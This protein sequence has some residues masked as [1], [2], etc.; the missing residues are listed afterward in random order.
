MT[1]NRAEI[2]TWAWSYARHAL[3]ARRAP[4]SELRSIFR[5]ALRLAWREAKAEAARRATAKPPR[6]AEVIRAE[7]FDLEMTDRLYAADMQRLR[8]LNAELNTSLSAARMA[9]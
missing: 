4:A 6:P 7:I 3:F 1:Y 5:D 9:A 8:A 2:M